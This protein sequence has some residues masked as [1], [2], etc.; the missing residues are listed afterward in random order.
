L[1]NEREEERWSWLLGGSSSL[2]ESSQV[3]TLV[4]TLPLLLLFSHMRS[5]LSF[6]AFSGQC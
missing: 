1:C 6:F 5:I 2:E 3:F 4:S